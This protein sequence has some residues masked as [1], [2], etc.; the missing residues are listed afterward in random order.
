MTTP[1]SA[2][3]SPVPPERQPVTMAGAL[4]RALADALAADDRVLVFGEDVGTLGGVFR[5]T[6]G[7]R[8]DSATAAC[9][10]TPLA[11]S[12]IVG[13]ADRHGDERPASRSSRCSSTRSPTPRSSRSPA[14]WPSCA[15]APAARVRLPMVIRVPFGGGIGG[16]EHHCDSSEAYYA[17]TPGLRVVTPGTPADAYRLLRAGD[18]LP[19]PGGL[20]RAE[21]ALLVQGDGRADRR[22]GRRHR[23]GPS[24]G[25]RARDVTLIAYGGDRSPPRSRPPTPP[26]RRAGTSRSSTC[27]RCR[28]FDD[29]TVTRVGAPDRPGRRWCTR[30]RLRRVRRRGR[31]AAHRACFH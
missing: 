27:A 14:I 5:I 24:C 29:A 6:D 22:T 23:T 1:L 11:E 10:D 8:R 26:P 30:P 28:P 18:R 25:G 16:V 4:N 9:F 15:T 21:A 19:R 13:T 17:H 12:G 20:P 31:R 7:L 2:H 3:R